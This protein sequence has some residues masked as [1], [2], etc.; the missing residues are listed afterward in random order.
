MSITPDDLNRKLERTAGGA[1]SPKRTA[2]HDEWMASALGAALGAASVAASSAATPDVSTDKQAKSKVVDDLQRG[3]EAA[4]EEIGKVL[5]SIKEPTLQQPASSSLEK[6]RPAL[7]AA[8]Q[9]QKPDDQAAALTVLQK[10]LAALKAE[11]EKAALESAA[12]LAARAR[13]TELSLKVEQELAEAGLA[14]KAIDEPALQAPQASVLDGLSKRQAAASKLTDPA[15]HE[16]ELS[17]LIVDIAKLK[18][19]AALA[20][21]K[22]D[23]LVQ[24]RQR[25]KALKDQI[26]TGL[27]EIK[28][29][30]ESIKEPTLRQPSAQA[31]ERLNVDL[32]AATELAS[33]GDQET[34]LAALLKQV[35][36]LKSGADKAAVD[37]D[38]LVK[39]RARVAAL[40]LQSEKELAEAD[41]AVKAIVEPALRDPEALKLDALSKRQVA[42]S[43]VTDPSIQ[44]Q[45]FSTL[46][47]DT[48][49]VKQDAAAAK[50]KA[51]ELAATRQRV[52]ALTA[53]VDLALTE[54]QKVIDGLKEKAFKDNLVART[55]PLTQE[56]ARITGLPAPGDQE[57]ALTKLQTDVQFMKGEAD[58]YVLWEQWL[59]DP[60]EKWSKAT[61]KWIDVLKEANAKSALQTEYDAVL[62]EQAGFVARLEFGSLEPVSMDKLKKVYG[63][64]K[65]VSEHGP[66]VDTEIHKLS[67]LV[68]SGMRDVTQ[69]SVIDPIRAKLEALETEKK[70]SWPAGANAAAMLTAMDT[71]DARIAAARADAET[72]RGK[73]LGKDAA[74]R[75]AK[76]KEIEDSLKGADQ[77][78][79]DFEG[80]DWK[81][82]DKMPEPGK[83]KLLE[84]KAQF[85]EARKAHKKLEARLAAVGKIKNYEAR[86]KEIV[87]LGKESSALVEQVMRPALKAMAKAGGAKMLDEM[88]GKMPN[89]IEKPAELAMCKAAI[90]ARFGIKIQVGDEFKA[91]SLP[92]LGKML[93]RVPEWQVKQAKQA[94]DGSAKEKSLKTLAYQNEPQAKG[95]YYSG[96]RKTIGLQGMTEKG[97]NDGHTL[98]A[99]SGKAVKTSYFDFTTLHEIGHAVDHRVNFMGQR[100]NTDGFGKWKKESFDSVLAAFLPSLVTACTG[101][102]K[103]AT[104]DDLKSL[105]TDLIKTGTCAKPASEADKLGSL[106]AEWDEI[107]RQPV[108]DKCKKGLYEKAKPWNKGKAL[109]DSVVVDG[110]VYQE[111]YANDWVSY[112]LADRATTG[113]TTYQWRAPGEW[114]AE[115]YALYY[116][117]KLSRSHPMSAWFRK[118]AKSESAAMKA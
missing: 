94:P 40:K 67:N 58:A 83:S 108:V 10:R 8:A 71:F 69:A 45:E 100:M 104:A 106:L 90:E 103:K 96:N 12:L 88:I 85:I 42:T 61:K 15:A 54:H 110:R 55:T 107:Q 49:K 65:R 48:A 76:T 97:S 11:A 51:D 99:D 105:L 5:Q 46:L 4:F 84:L 28:P 63:A 66:E 95:N 21:G 78:L 116:L 86:G 2:E 53:T 92:R 101:G 77:V 33:P 60:W 25:V 62:Q 39:A 38:A 27:G 19:D 72:A 24:T 73:L 36:P 111:A 59:Q 20:K 18:Q 68:L 64:A 91:K 43:K 37:S 23:E 7:T 98:V 109:A 9:L 30:L 114:F 6:L 112:A 1:R 14:I 115:I 81:A 47:T 32:K 56:R 70:A 13:I 50:V 41:V 79:G 52:A 17:T 29:V 93:A 3:A 89:N 34:A 118:S 113:V 35:A 57:S 80:Q 82:I 117:N 102:S 22:S 26:D 74:L 16:Q 75:E 44:E 31:L 87:A